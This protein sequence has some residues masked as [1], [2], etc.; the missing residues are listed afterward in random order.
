MA[1]WNSISFKKE[2]IVREDMKGILFKLPTNI[3]DKKYSGYMFYHRKGMVKKNNDG[4]I[5]SFP[6]TWNFNFF[7]EDIDK[8]VVDQ[9]EI[10]VFDFY[11]IVL[12]IILN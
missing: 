10:K 9:Q 2:D 11:K 4:V 5:F 3:N 12:G 7:K 8:E 6:N 1:N